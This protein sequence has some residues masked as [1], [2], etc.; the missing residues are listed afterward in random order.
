VSHSPVTTRGEQTPAEMLAEFHDT[1][2][3]ERGRGNAA[4]RLTLHEEEHRELG[5]ELGEWELPPGGSYPHRVAFTDEKVDRAKLARELADV[6]YVAYGTAHAF[7]IDLEVALTEVHRAAMSKLDP[8][9]SRCVEGMTHDLYDGE[10]V[11]ERCGDCG[12]TGK[13]EPV[14][15]RDGKVLKPAGFIPPDMSEAIQ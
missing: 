11:T 2:G 3:D 5:D 9:C 8:P 14:V 7:G 1:L 4:L 15:R 10:P 13:G 6:V 12:G